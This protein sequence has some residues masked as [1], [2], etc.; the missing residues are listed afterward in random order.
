MGFTV[1]T[2]NGN[3]L[4]NID[5]F[6]VIY[7]GTGAELYAHYD[8]SDRVRLIGG[9][10]YFSPDDPDASLDDDFEVKYGVLGINYFFT[11]NTL[12]YAEL[13]LDNGTTADG[14]DGFHVITVG[15]LWD[16]SF[17]P[18]L[19]DGDEENGL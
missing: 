15:A 11:A 3:E 8:L 9:W 12:A 1:A 2:E 4:A 16:F 17:K 14:S 18:R 10:N 5:D 13:R 7:D 19:P 6:S